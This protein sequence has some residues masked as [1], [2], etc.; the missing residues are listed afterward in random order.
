M[1]NN[2]PGETSHTPPPP[3]SEALT[4][5]T[6]ATTTSAQLWA[7][8]RSHSIQYHA[9]NHERKTVLVFE[10]VEA[11]TAQR[12]QKMEQLWIRS[13]EKNSV[14]FDLRH[15]AFLGSSFLDA[16]H[17]QYPEAIGIDSKHGDHNG[18][19]VVAFDS[20]AA[21]VQAC[22]IGVTVDSLTIVATATVDVDSHV[23]RLHLE[24][25]PLLRPNELAPL[26]TCALAPYGKVL[27]VNMYTDQRGLFFG[28]GSA[29]I[30]VNNTEVSYKPLSHEIPLGSDRLF[31]AKW[32]G[33]PKHCFYCK[34]QDHLRANCPRRK[35]GPKLCFGCLLYPS[36]IL[37][38]H[39]LLA[40]LIQLYEHGRVFFSVFLMNRSLIRID[41]LF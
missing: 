2:S 25:L 32:R 37:H 15:H 29:T 22:T 34:K 36:N 23:Y 39:S 28:K 1:A 19:A 6:D 9:R 41:H 24:G 21:K 40:C 20:H 8:F 12:Q 26:V 35:R 7:Q 38:I 27:H 5:P 14:V 30:A 4:T 17:A 33:M 31:Y 16:L 18:I 11:K 13:A 10:D 3:A